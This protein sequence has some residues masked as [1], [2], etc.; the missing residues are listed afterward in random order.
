MKLEKLDIDKDNGE[1]CFLKRITD[2]NLSYYQKIW[3]DEDQLMGTYDLFKKES[4]DFFFP[5][6]NFKSNK[7]ELSSYLS[8]CPELVSRI[9]K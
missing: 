9:I 4:Q 7:N 8:E 1:I 5:A 2:G 6:G 3:W